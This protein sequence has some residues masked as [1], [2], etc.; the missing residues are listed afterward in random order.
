MQAGSLV[1]S[2]YTEYGIKITF[3]VWNP[4]IYWQKHVE[5]ILAKMPC[6]Q[7]AAKLASEVWYIF[8]NFWQQ[9]PSNNFMFISL[10]TL[11]I[12]VTFIL[13]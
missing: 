2:K 8:F 11:K 5:Y 9:S 1:L 3:V 13:K 4:N 7:S 10:P 12:L 6:C